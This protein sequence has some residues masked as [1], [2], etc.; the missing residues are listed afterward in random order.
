MKLQSKGTRD[1]HVVNLEEAL[2]LRRQRNL[3]MWRS[4]ERD[5]RRRQLYRRAGAL[6]LPI[7]PVIMIVALGLVAAVYFRGAE[8]R[9]GR[10]TP[11]GGRW[12]SRSGTIWPAGA[13]MRPVPSAWLP[14]GPES[15]ATGP[16]STQTVTAS[17]ANHG[18]VGSG[19]PK[20][21]APPC[22]QCPKR[23]RCRGPSKLLPSNGRRSLDRIRGCG[24]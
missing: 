4:H 10:P 15:R 3:Q 5:M 2:L 18:H 1:G 24:T 12:R 19:G 17:P 21:R 13:V 14:R 8:I 11:A 6:L 20:R 16:T 7:G 22:V 23:V 9:A